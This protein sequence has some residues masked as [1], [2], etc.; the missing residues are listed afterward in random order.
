[1]VNT[2]TLKKLRPGL[3][4]VIKDIDAKLDRYIVMK[5]GKPVAVMLN[6]DDYEGLLETIEILSDKDAVRRIKKAKRDIAEGKTITLEDLRRK[7]EQ[8][9]V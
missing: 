5:R 1:M 3:P 2:I 9:N 7:I 6:P 4:K 8:L